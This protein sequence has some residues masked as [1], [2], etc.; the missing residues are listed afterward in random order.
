MED[1]PQ[2]GALKWMEGI[3][4]DFSRR[5]YNLR[6]EVLLVEEGKTEVFQ[7][8]I[9][10]NLLFEGKMAAMVNHLAAQYQDKCQGES[11]PYVSSWIEY[12]HLNYWIR[13]C[14][15]CHL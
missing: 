10:A 2:G 12:L 9:Y 15:H 3:R 6:A 4:L 8:V 7:S 13:C 5:Y 11:P 1:L 14:A